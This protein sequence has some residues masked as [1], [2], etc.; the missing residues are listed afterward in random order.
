MRSSI[1]VLL[2]DDHPVVHQG[3]HDFCA[4]AGDIELIGIAE[5]GS[6]TRLLL[7][8]IQPDILLLDLQMPD[9]DPVANIRFAQQYC[10]HTRVI[11]FSAFC[12][13][14]SVS[15][16]VER[17]IHGYV[18]KTEGLHMVLDA[19][20]R[21]AQG[22]KWFSQ[23]VLATLSNRIELPM[24]R[25]KL[26]A[27]ECQIVA[28]IGKGY[29]NEQIADKLSLSKQTVAN[30]IPGIYVKIDVSSRAEAIVW[31]MEAESRSNPKI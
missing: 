20:R 31:W 4:D 22:E 25:Y 19:V 17:G 12:D 3:L 6:Q 28:L 16:L 21:V 15:E 5:D 18:V 2:A 27:R 29:S 11:I 26:T 7:Q 8:Q 24:S 10:P 9:N 23:Q 14:V 30:Y 13:A 1:R